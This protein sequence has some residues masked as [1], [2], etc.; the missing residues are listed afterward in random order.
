MKTNVILKSVD[1]ELFGTTVRQHTSTEML[2]VTDLMKGY[3]KARYMHG[4]SVRRINDVLK[5]KTFQERLFYTLE[6]LG[7]IKTTIVVFMEMVEKEGVAKVMKKLGVWK[8]TGR[9]ENKMVVANPYIWI[10][11]AL[12]LNPKIYAKVVVWLTDG[13]IVN[14]IEAATNYKP[15]TSAIKEIANKP[16]YKDIAIAMNERVFGRHEKGIRNTASVEQLSL[17]TKIEESIFQ[18]IK[19]GAIDSEAG[20]FALIKRY[21]I[22]K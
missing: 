15:M 22:I 19:M 14:R 10:A 4:W 7:L 13:L 3:E 20:V 8:T 18:F 17:I 2:S 5:Y 12:E 6:E 21:T 9:G 1:R 16:N 11:L